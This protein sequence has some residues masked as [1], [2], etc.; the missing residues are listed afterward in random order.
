MERD[1]RL[2]FVR[3]VALMMI[4][5]NHMPG[6]VFSYITFQNLGFS[7]AAEVFV[8]VA[9]ISAYLAYS[10][11]FARDGV[12]A[13]TL[14]ILGRARQ[15]YVV[16]LVLFLL[17][18]AMMAWAATQF[19]DPMYL[20]SMSLD[21]LVQDPAAA[22]LR[23]VTLT[24]QPRFLDILPLYVALMA[25]LP[26]LL[27]LFRVGAFAPLAASL[28]LFAVARWSG[29]NLPNLPESRSWFFNPF[30][31]QL[32]FVIG[33]TV[34]H[35]QRLGRWHVPAPRLVTLAAAA[36]VAFAFAAAAPWTDI[37]ALANASLFP[38]GWL[39]P[40]NKTNLSLFRLCNVLAQAWLLAVLMS[41]AC[42]LLATR[43]G[44]AMALA[45]RNSLDVFA[46]G[47]VLST[48][49]AILLKG[50]QYDVTVQ[51][52]YTVGGVAVMVAYAGLIEWWKRERLASRAAKAPPPEPASFATRPSAQN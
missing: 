11:A 16:H 23:A 41:R 32:L 39:P 22:I 5:I 19:A 18:T 6:N 31:W 1:A 12:V 7:D 44:R 45:G 8:L 30:A 14:A 3:G 46:L 28:A 49:G 20:E 43:A 4:F 50:T 25:L 9:G 52:A 24:Y 33:L 48:G 40:V 21:L 17:V 38:A 51:V 34:A 47:T 10:H 26:A 27:L 15:L 37:P 36:Y 42:P 2:D 35:L 29:L 13:T